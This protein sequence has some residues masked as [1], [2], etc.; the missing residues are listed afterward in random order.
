MQEQP[1]KDFLAT[2]ANN[3]V[4]L[5]LI[6][7]LIEHPFSMDNASGLAKWLNLD[8][9][10]VVRALGE[11]SGAGIVHASGSGERTIWSFDPESP[12]AETAKQSAR[13]WRLTRDS[14]REQLLDLERRE[15][16]LHERYEAILSAERGKT[17]TV[18]NSLEEAVLVTGHG[19]TVLLA[20]GA[21]LRRFAAGDS[22]PAAGATLGEI[23]RE[24]SVSDVVRRSLELSE[25][26]E[27]REIDFSCSGS[28]Y[29]VRS[30]PVTGADGKV[31]TG[32]DGERL[33][34][35]TVF[36]DVT[37]EHEIERMREDFISML[38]H[39]L[40]NP[41][42]IIFGSTTLVVGGKLGELNEKQKRLLTNAIR[43][44]GTM[45][46]LIQDF[47]TVSRLEAGRLNL[48]PEVFD[49]NTLARDILDLFSDQV[50]E[51]GLKVSFRAEYEDGRLLADPV[52]VERVLTNL[53]GNAVKYNE[54]GGHIT[55][56]T[57]EDPEGTL[58][59][60][61]ADN[62]PGIPEDDLPYIFERYRRSSTC[63]RT[64]G[65]GLG[66]AVVRQ[67]VDA[68][69]G[70]INASSRPGEGACFTF[71]LPLEPSGSRVGPRDHS[72]VL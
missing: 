42:G 72:S 9:E 47:L 39:D 22:A 35:V 25:T 4:K 26:G 59:V 56:S 55:L 10:R 41:L 33:A 63:G 28:C 40:V 3:T 62:G 14:L 53:V 20:N 58:R 15:D 38:T 51:K 34:A 67:L 64:K 30:V 13:A 68:M 44:C 49:I 61:V 6:A 18:L 57:A 16:E 65:S 27:D 37:R 71:T 43:S 32:A 45:E 12:L 11:L 70:E 54:E 69:G 24:R 7:W 21:M 5:E 60:S 46:R 29:R 19:D 36:R 50:R 8:E 17:E 52:Q 1:V 31:M 2:V 48:N 23:F 66:L